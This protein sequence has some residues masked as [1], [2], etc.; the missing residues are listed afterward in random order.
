[1]VQIFVVFA[2]RLATAKIKTTKI[3]MGGENDDVIMNERC[4]VRVNDRSN[5]RFG[6][7]RPPYLCSL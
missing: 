1:M 4:T 6:H 5:D 2:D 7:V 3:S